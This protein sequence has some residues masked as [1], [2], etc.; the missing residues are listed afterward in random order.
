MVLSIRVRLGWTFSER[1]L[2]LLM[3]ILI[4][5]S[6][7]VVQL[8]ITFKLG[9]ARVIR[10]MRLIVPLIILVMVV[11]ILVTLIVSHIWIRVSLRNW[12]IL[13]WHRWIICCIDLILWRRRMVDVVIVIVSTE[14]IITIL[15]KEVVVWVKEASI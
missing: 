10:L 13:R 12:C 14:L 9:L 5:R 3:V 1:V 4:L 15:I 8:M 6:F 11:G 2:L 7:L